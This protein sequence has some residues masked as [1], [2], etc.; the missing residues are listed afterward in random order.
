MGLN[1]YNGKWEDISNWSV[2]KIVAK[3][4]EIEKERQMEIAECFR[5]VMF[6]NEQLEY[7]LAGLEK[8]KQKEE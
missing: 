6:K 2:E 4:R 3:I 7:L 8:M 1:K 5:Y